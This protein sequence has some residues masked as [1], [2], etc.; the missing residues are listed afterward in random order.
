[1]RKLGQIL[2]AGTTLS[3]IVSVAAIEIV[4][5]N[6]EFGNK[7]VLERLAKSEGTA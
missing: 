4:K 1:M 3:A 2:L 5:A 6:V 7:T